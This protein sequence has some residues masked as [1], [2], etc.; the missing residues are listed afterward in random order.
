M[1]LDDP[2]T[3]ATLPLNVVIGCMVLGNA[4]AVN[5]ASYSRQG[6]GRGSAGGVI[7]K[8]IEVVH[9]DLSGAD[10]VTTPGNNLVHG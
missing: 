5:T 2:V 9:V 3:M 8:L 6:G 7:K 4:Q 1:P 10:V